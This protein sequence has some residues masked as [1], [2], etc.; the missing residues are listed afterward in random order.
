VAVN[1]KVNPA[2]SQESRWIYG[3]GVVL[4]GLVVVALVFVVAALRFDKA[5]DVSTAVGSVTGVVGTLVGAYFGVQAGS[6]GKDKS[7]AAR[8]VAEDRALHLAARLN[9]ADATSA[10]AAADGA[11]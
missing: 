4:L 6:A 5:A 8:K 10:L 2:P 3:A 1:N 7:E 11:S 9:P